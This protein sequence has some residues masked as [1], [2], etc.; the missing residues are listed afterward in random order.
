MQNVGGTAHRPSIK[1]KKQQQVKGEIILM[2]R[3]TRKGKVGYR[4]SGEKKTPSRDIS[5]FLTKLPGRKGF[6]GTRPTKE[7]K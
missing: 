3:G 6:W 7:I 4:T 5:A 1:G 2:A